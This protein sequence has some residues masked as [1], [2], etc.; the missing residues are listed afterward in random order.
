[1]KMLTCAQ[2]GGPCDA[3]IMGSTTDEMMAN[4]MKHLEEAH[5]DMA[6]NVKAMPKDDPMMISWNEKF[7]ADWE[8]APEV[9][10]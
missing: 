10:A 5:P 1:M 9:G 4:G 3:E 6:A 8:A 2:L 7:M